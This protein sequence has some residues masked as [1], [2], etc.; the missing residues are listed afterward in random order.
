MIPTQNAIITIIIMK[1]GTFAA[2]TAA[3]NTAAIKKQSTS[4]LFDTDVDFISIYI[5]YRCIRELFF[6]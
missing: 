5:P 2:A 4:V 6:H 1:K 3:E